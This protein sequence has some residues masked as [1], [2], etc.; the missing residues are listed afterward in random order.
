MIYV[1]RRTKFLFIGLTIL[2]ALTLITL[3]LVTELVRPLPAFFVWLFLVLL[4]AVIAGR[5]AEKLNHEI[6]DTL[7]KKCNPHGYIEKLEKILNRRTGDISTILL[8]NVSTGY[9]ISGDMQKARRILETISIQNNFSDNRA[10]IIN[11]WAYYNNFCSY[12]LNTDDITNAEIMLNNMLE[13][14]K[15]EKF[16]K[17]QYDAH[18]NYYI[19]KQFLINIAKG[20]YAGAEQWYLIQFDREKNLFGKVV[21]QYHLGRIYLHVERFEEAEKAFN[22]VIENGNTT[23]YVAKAREFLNQWPKSEELT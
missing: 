8:L 12:F 14:L 5:Y 3:I 21:A 1:F 7:T 9:L 23:R 16:P 11:K 19:D 10:G 15:N 17:Q 22:Y 2:S 18:Y 4:S 13:I 20:D 6:D